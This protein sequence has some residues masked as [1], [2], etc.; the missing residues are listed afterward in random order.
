MALIDKPKVFQK[1]KD[2]HSKV[3]ANN[4]KIGHN[5]RGLDVNL[6][7]ACNLRC[8]HCF[9]NSPLGDHVKEYIP[10]DVIA[11]VSD[12]AHELGVFEFDLQGGE[13]LLNKPRLYETL[14]AIGTDRFYTYVTTNGFHMDS[15][16]ASQLKKLGVD[17]VSVSIDSIDPSVHDSFRGK[18]GSWEKALAA[19][20]LVQDAGID[21]YLNITVGRYNAQSEDVRALL[22]LSR[23]QKYTTLINVATPA[24]MWQKLDEIMINDADRAYLIEMRKQYKNILRNLWDP[25][26]RSREAVL[27]CNTVNR[28]Y[29]TPLG[30]VLACPYVHI[31]IGNVYEESL[32]EIRDKGF[33]FSKFSDH[34]ELC[35]A[36]EDRSFV[37][38][39]MSD[40]GT[41]IFNPVDVNDIIKR[42]DSAS[43]AEQITH[44]ML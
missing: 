2:F 10:A 20:A 13:L 32:R 8:E 6:N 41:S 27:G 44:K 34:S 30:D 38:R 7:N 5:H 14:E 43:R 25:F 18:K 11:R 28:M 39:Y 23:D 42:D 22:E 37:N 31:K 15:D 26:D 16:T 36:G 29:I 19:L 1:F 35:L 33:S 12:E 21:P 24:G 9:T 17:R 3:K 40:A 4:G